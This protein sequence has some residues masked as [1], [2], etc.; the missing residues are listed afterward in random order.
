MLPCAQAAG[1]AGRA[2][3]MRDRPSRQG[4]T[5]MRGVAEAPR[6]ADRAR[7]GPGAMPGAQA[8]GAPL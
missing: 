3:A 8:G 1:D 7:P 6:L 4:Q 5:A 2:A